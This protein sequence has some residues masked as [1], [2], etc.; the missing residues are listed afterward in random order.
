MRISD[1][2]SDV[3]S[4]DLMLASPAVNS[5]AVAQARAQS[6]RCGQPAAG[7]SEDKARKTAQDFEAF[8]MSQMFEFMSS[9]EERRVGK[10]GGSPCRSR[11]TPNPTKQK[12]LDETNRQIRAATRSTYH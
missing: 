1:W 10:E 12:N 2:S 9:S 5:Y 8:F 3:C 4:S 7:S 11:W 6:A